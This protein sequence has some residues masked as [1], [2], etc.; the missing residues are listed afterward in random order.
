MTYLV[1]FERGREGGFGAWVPDLPGCVAA[2]ASRAECEQAIREAIAF[3]IEGM[4]ERGEPV[5]ASAATDA[6]LVTC[7]PDVAAGRPVVA[8]SGSR[9]R[10]VATAE[11]VRGLQG[12]PQI[13]YAAMR[14][15]IDASLG[16][17]D[18]VG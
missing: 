16:P 14:A 13:D 6:V 17:D 7:Q 15:E 5:P 3:H 8:E 11:L 4:R 9:R 2:G 10:H 18:I 12:L 1:V